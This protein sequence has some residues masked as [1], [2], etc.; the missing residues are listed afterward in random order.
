MFKTLFIPSA[1]CPSARDPL[2]QVFKPTGKNIKDYYI[3]VYDTWGN[4]LWESTKLDRDGR[5]VESW[6]GKYNN[7]LLPTG[8]YI[9]QA[10]AQFLDGTIWEGTSVGNNEGSSGST[11]GTVTLVR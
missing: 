4:L 10:S 5:P 1:L 3:A 6:D 7:E 2:V 8:V 9:W 11:S